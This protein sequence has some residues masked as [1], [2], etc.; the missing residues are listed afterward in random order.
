MRNFFNSREP[1]SVPRMTLLHGVNNAIITFNNG[2]NKCAAS[3]GFFDLYKPSLIYCKTYCFFGC[4]LY[5]RVSC[6]GEVMCVLCTVLRCLFA[7][8]FR[9]PCFVLASFD[10]CTKYRIFFMMACLSFKFDFSHLVS[11]CTYSLWC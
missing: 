4:L 11:A 9:T 2:N 1:V 8:C 10:Y 5:L 3:T 6:V 7:E